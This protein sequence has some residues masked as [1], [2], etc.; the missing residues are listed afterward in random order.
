MSDRRPAE[1]AR[2]WPSKETVMKRM[3]DVVAIAL[4]LLT[5]APV[6]PATNAGSSNPQFAAVAAWPTICFEFAFWKYCI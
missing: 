5:V 2:G 6:L 4:V 1:R 3:L